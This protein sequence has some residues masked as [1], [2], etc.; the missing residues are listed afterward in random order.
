MSSATRTAATI[1][2]LKA[3]SAVQPRAGKATSTTVHRRKPRSRATTIASRAKT[4]ATIA[5]T[6]APTTTI[7]MTAAT[8]TAIAAI[9]RRETTGQIVKIDQSVTIVEIA[10]LNRRAANR[11]T[12]AT[13]AA[14]ITQI[15]AGSTTAPTVMASAAASVS[16]GM[17]IP[18]MWRQAMLAEAMLGQEAS[19]LVSPGKAR[20]RQRRSLL[21]R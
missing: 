15:K 18:A 11:A 13:I 8:A 4:D 14:R 9:G 3:M 16:K 21:S 6:I 7:E 12:A 5:A 2:A 1:S 17:A 10:L 19:A 20:N